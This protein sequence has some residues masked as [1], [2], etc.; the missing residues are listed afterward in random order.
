MS[1]PFQRTLPSV[2]FEIVAS[3][4]ISVVFPAPFGPRSPMTPGASESEK[5]LSPQTSALYRLLTCSIMRFMVSRRKCVRRIP[6]IL[7]PS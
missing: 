1:V 3:M 2:G 4:R 6:R 7:N 5:S